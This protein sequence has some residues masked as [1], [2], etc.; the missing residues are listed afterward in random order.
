MT[1]AQSD[2]F[3]LNCIDLVPKIFIKRMEIVSCVIIYEIIHKWNLWVIL[4][5]K[6]YLMKY[7]SRPSNL[8]TNDI[9]IN[10]NTVYVSLFAEMKLCWLQFEG[11]GEIKLSFPSWS[12]CPLQFR[13]KV[14][15]ENTFLKILK[16]EIKDISHLNKSVQLINKFLGRY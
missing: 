2:T 5:L 9:F 4:N 15:I 7:F 10:Q 1:K 13:N 8:M 3:H 14:P 16:I 12:F 6:E 11:E